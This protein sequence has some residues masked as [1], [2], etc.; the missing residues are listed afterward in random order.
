MDPHSRYS[1]FNNQ[2]GRPKTGPE[3]QSI[4]GVKVEPKTIAVLDHFRKSDSA[5]SFSSS[6]SASASS[7]ELKSVSNR[8]IATNSRV[9]K[10]ERYGRNMYLAFIDNAL[11]QK[12]RV[13]VSM[14]R[15]LKQVL[16]RSLLQGVSEHYDDLVRQFSP[17][18]SASSSDTRQ[19]PTMIQ[20]Q[21]LRAYL[22]ALSHVVSKLDRSHIV[23]I[24]AIVGMPWT[25]M[26][27]A[28]VKAY[29]SFVSMLVSARP[30]YLTLVLERAAQNL[31][32][33]A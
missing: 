22:T 17:G 29:I 20:Q 16:I 9:R 32:Y 23:L 11:V 5:G 12:A 30:E 28:F 4:R 27:S 10:N 3:L 21:Q 33:R 15:I 8:P 13:R 14:P 18:S 2:A 6:S 31:T 19:Q 7:S 25:I 24:D 26:D 1:P